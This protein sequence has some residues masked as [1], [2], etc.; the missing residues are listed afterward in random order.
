M[1]RILTGLMVAALIATLA[2]P[3]FAKDKIKIAYVEWSCSTAT[4]NV[5]KAVLQ[6]R[7]GY[8]VEILPVAA[9][10]MWQA[11]ATGDVDGM[12]S[13]WLPNTQADYLE[14]MK[15]KVIDLGPNVT[16][17]RLGWAVPDYVTVDSIADLNRYADKFKGRVIGIDPGAGIM[18]LSEKALE[19]YKLDDMELMEGSGATMTASLGMAIKR[20]EWVVVTAWSPHWLFGRWNVKYLD[21]PKGTLGK[22]ETINTV[23]RLGLKEDHPD[24]YS[25]LDK[26]H[27]KDVNQLQ[28]VMAWNQEEGADPYE[29]AKKFIRENKEQVDSWLK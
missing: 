27:W 12:A 25:F 26:F 6:E 3:A 15:D 18:R 29:N 2:V 10:V 19:D 14:R 21:D 20:N 17:A 23:V 13:A 28:M 24:V 5:V 9:A 11:T 8:D 16:G 1:K 22:A 7:M 4:T